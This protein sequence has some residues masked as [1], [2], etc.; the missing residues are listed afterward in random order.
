MKELNFFDC[1]CRIGINNEHMPDAAELLSEMDH[2]GIDRA[3]VFHNAVHLG[4]EVTN[5]DLAGMLEADTEKRLTGVWCILPDS[6]DELGNIDDFFNDMTKNRIKALTLD[7]FNH[8]YLPRRIVIGKIMDAAKERKIP[9][10]L[11]AFATPG[12]WNDMYDF[13]AEFPDNIFIYTENSGIWGL[14]RIFRPLLETYEN[15]YFD[16]ARYW[17]PEGIYDLVKKY[18]SDR[19]LY[20]SG[21]PYFNHGSSMLQLKNSKLSDEDLRK[22]CSG[23]LERILGEVQI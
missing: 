5:R 17:V 7:P 1:N 10:M 15:F 18:G 4:A 11:N 12:H 19:I 21:F 6:C 16:T 22:I 2:Y 13:M 14:D 9:I 23:N 20:G 8:R 3:L